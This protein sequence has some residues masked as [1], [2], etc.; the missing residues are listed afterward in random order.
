VYIHFPHHGHQ[1]LF[2]ALQRLQGTR[3]VAVVPDPWNSTFDAPHPGIPRPL[4]GAVPLSSPIGRPLIPLG[5]QVLADFQLHQL[6]GE[7]SH[8]VSQKLGVLQL[9]LTQEL[10]PDRREWTLLKSSAIASVLLI[11]DVVSLDEN[12]RWPSI[13]T[14]RITP[15]YGNGT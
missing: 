10:L 5:S 3:E 7:H 13:S 9:R 4:S 1:R 8:P 6:L 11:G 14:G 12:H 15:L 2:G